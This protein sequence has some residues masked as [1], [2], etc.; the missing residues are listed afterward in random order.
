MRKPIKRTG[1]PPKI[2]KRIEREWIKRKKQMEWKLRNDNL[3]N[4]VI[5]TKLEEEWVSH[6][7]DQLTLK[8]AGDP[9]P[10]S[11]VT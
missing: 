3:K 5:K 2:S 9:P 11:T 7:I 6:V 4:Q 10:D 1:R 8:Q